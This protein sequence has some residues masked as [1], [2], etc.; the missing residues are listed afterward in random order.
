M[1]TKR[2]SMTKNAGMLALFA[3]A[4]TLLVVVVNYFTEPRIEQQVKA[5]LIRSTNEVLSEELANSTYQQRCIVVNEPQFLGNDKD[6]T[7]RLIELNQETAAFVYQTIAPDGY[8]GEIRLLVGINADSTISGVRVVQHNETPGLGDKVETRKSDWIYQFNGQRLMDDKDPRWAVK[9]DGGQ[10]D[11]FTG[12]TI[13]PRAV[14]KAVKNVL[15]YH[16]TNQQ[17]INDNATDC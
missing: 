17:S 5:Q 7:I 4:C 14:I 16:S 15:I 3:F 9:K 2:Q 6:Q 13:T 8:S 10:F 11:A 1:T 12:A